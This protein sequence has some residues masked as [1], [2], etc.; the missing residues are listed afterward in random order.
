[1]FQT[2]GRGIGPWAASCQEQIKERGGSVHMNNI[3]TVILAIEVPF[4]SKTALAVDIE[5]INSV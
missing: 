5:Y 2:L 4:Q 1:M 3:W